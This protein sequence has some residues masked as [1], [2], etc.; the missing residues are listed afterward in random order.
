MSDY[1]NT[2]VYLRKLWDDLRYNLEIQLKENGFDNISPS[3]GWVF[4]HTDANGSRITDLAA[5]AKITKQS[6]SVLVAQLENDGYV[7]KT[8][9]PNDKRAWLLLL[10]A[11][12]KKVK[13]VGQQINFEFEEEWK[14]KLGE[15]DYDQLRQLLKRL[16]E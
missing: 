10:T 1:I 16:C 6:M 13:S 7:K 9:D 4:Y 14:K 11:K 5:K 12:G 15:K 2:G 8:P 3:H